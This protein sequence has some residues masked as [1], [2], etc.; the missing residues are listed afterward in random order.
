MNK[1]LL[2]HIQILKL[3]FFI[4]KVVFQSSNRPLHIKDAFLLS[5]QSHSRNSHKMTHNCLGSDDTELFIPFGASLQ[6]DCHLLLIPLNQLVVLL[7]SK[8]QAGNLVVQD[9]NISKEALLC[10]VL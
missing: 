2:K 4:N 1:L 6:H 10:V 5:V 3:V 9:T 7:L 8:L